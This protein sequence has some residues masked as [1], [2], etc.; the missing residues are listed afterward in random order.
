MPQKKILMLAFELPPHNSGGL[1]VACLGMTKALAKKGFEIF[2]MLPKRLDY[3]YS[4]MKILFSEDFSKL[5]E[6]V[7]KKK[8]YVTKK[9]TNLSGYMLGDT[10]KSL[11]EE[12]EKLTHEMVLASRSKDFDVIHAHDWM[13]FEA[14]IKIKEDSGK[15]LIVHIHSTELDRSPHFAI[16]NYKYE[17]EKKGMLKADAVVT[18]SHHTKNIVHK[19]YNIPL[20]KIFVMYNATYLDNPSTSLPKVSLDNPL[21]VFLGRITHQK[22]PLFLLEAAKKTI[23]KEPKTIFVVVGNGDMY[24]TMIEKACEFGLSGN[25]IFTNFLRGKYRDSLL[26]RADVFVM[27][28]L[29]EPFGLVALEAAHFDTP[30]IVSKQSGVGEVLKSSIQV[31]FWDTDLLSK[32]IHTLIKKKRLRKDLVKKHKE[33][34]KNIT[35]EKTTESISHLYHN[36]SNKEI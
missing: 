29:S 16:D 22:G 26:K 21:V 30:V 14:G 34:L 19:F 4:H 20:D 8:K 2:F 1:G 25:I 18:V 36:L 32:K 27:P 13:T 11:E 28:S 33:E 23:E 12:M 6:N 35:W 3:N 17:V 10:S 7:S 15:P 24:E 31:D 5:P 9:E